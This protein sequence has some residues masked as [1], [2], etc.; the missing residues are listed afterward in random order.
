MG[1]PSTHLPTHT[2]PSPQFPH[3]FPWQVPGASDQ[4]SVSDAL[5]WEQK[6]EAAEAL[7]ALRNSSWAPLDAFPMHQ[8]S[9][10]VS[11]L[12]P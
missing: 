1:G 12:L 10:P 2:P 7:V 4:A 11:R 8:P 3:T 5:E 6:L 9:S